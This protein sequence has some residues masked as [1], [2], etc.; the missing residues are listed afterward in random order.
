MRGR[1]HKGTKTARNENLYRASSLFI[2]ILSGADNPSS[3]YQLLRFCLSALPTCRYL[4][5]LDIAFHALHN[6]RYPKL[7]KRF[8][9]QRLSLSESLNLSKFVV[10]RSGYACVRVGLDE[11]P[12][13]IRDWCGHREE[14]PCSSA[15]F[16]ALQTTIN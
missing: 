13:F 15:S 4:P 8:S 10:G 12:L 7:G 3:R 9:S 2:S 14:S 16:Y 1:L 11:S 6:G 5:L